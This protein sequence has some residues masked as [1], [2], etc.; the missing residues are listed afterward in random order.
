MVK[1][2]FFLIW[3]KSLHTAATNQITQATLLGLRRGPCAR[4]NYVNNAHIFLFELFNAVAYI[5][6]YIRAYD[7]QQ[8]HKNKNKTTVNTGYAKLYLAFPRVIQHLHE[9]TDRGCLTGWVLGA[10]DTLMKPPVPFHH[11]WEIT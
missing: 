5:F 2:T 3:P 8:L 9:T 6:V 7:R 1:Q 4:D 10:V 11:A